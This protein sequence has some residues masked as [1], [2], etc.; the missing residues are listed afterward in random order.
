M[1]EA[2]RDRSAIRSLTGKYSQNHSQNTEFATNISL[3]WGVDEKQRR[4]RTIRHG[5]TLRFVVM[6]IT[7]KPQNFAEALNVFST[8]R[9]RWDR[10]RSC[11]RKRFGPESFRG[12]A[13]I[14]DYLKTRGV[15]VVHIVDANKTELH[16]YTSAARIVGGMLSYASDRDRL[17]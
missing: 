15:E 16:P 10:Q 13:L 1:Y 2:C 9:T 14:S 7:W 12:R 6:P 17:I 4:I 8:L 11:A 3:N 5:A